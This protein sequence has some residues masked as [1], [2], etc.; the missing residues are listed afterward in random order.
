MNKAVLGVNVKSWRENKI[1]LLQFYAS[2]KEQREY[3]EA[4][5]L[6]GDLLGEFAEWWFS[7]YPEEGEVFDEVWKT[8]FTDNELIGIKAFTD[9]FEVVWKQLKDQSLNIEPLIA[10]VF[11]KELGLKAILLKKK[12]DDS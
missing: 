7:D 3:A 11:W 9:E 8:A 1:S 2:H 12:L 6:E 10:S 4:V 5:C